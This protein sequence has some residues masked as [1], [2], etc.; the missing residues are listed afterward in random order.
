MSIDKIIK[1]FKK[2]SSYKLIKIIDYFGTKLNLYTKIIN[3][4]G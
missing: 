4:L 1:N 3:N 2:N